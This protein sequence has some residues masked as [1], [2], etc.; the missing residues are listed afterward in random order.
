MIAS[1]GE[2][3]LVS[4][5]FAGAVKSIHPEDCQA[6][7]QSERVFPLDLQRRARVEAKAQVAIE[8][9]RKAAESD[10]PLLPGEGIFFRRRRSGIV[11]T[12][13][14]QDAARQQRHP[15]TNADSSNEV[16]L[17]VGTECLTGRSHKARV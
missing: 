17:V 15:N 6:G 2:I 10:R 11:S 13:T 8:G 9:R 14:I 16:W 4:A 12:N 3:Q 5:A 1:I 7:I